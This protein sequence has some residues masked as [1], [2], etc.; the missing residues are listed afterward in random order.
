MPEHQSLEYVPDED[1]KSLL[2]FCKTKS[3]ESITRITPR[4]SNEI[5]RRSQKALIGYLKKHGKLALQIGAFILILFLVWKLCQFGYQ[6]YQG[7]RQRGEIPRSDF[8]REHSEK[9]K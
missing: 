1:L 5:K 8:S 3:A 4:C 6:K 9:T 7:Y 2:E